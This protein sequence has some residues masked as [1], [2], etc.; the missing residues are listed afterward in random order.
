M[1]RFGQGIF[2]SL[3]AEKRRLLQDK[4]AHSSMTGLCAVSL[5]PTVLRV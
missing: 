2:A 1:E 5:F 3:L 4:A